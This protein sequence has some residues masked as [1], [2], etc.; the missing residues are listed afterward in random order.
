MSNTSQ[1]RRFFLGSTLAA[2][3]LAATRSDRVIAAAN[4]NSDVN[5]G[6]IA[7][8]GRYGKLNNFFSQVDGVQITGLC[9][10]DEDRVG[11]A[12]AS[13][14]KAK[15]WSDLRDLIADPNIDAV[16]ISTCNHWHCLASIW[17]M[18]AGKHVYVEKPLSHSQWEGQQCVA[19]AEK[20]KRVVQVGTHQRSDPMQADI[21]KFL[22]ED[23]TLGEIKYVRANRFGV[24]GSI[25]KRDTPLEIEKSVAYDLWLGPA[26]DLPIMRNNLQYDWHWDWNTGSGE[27]G[28]WGVHILDDIRNV[29]YQDRIPLPKRVMAGGG[30]VVWDDAGN[31]PNVHF[32]YF[33]TGEAPVILGLTNV[34]G[35]VDGAKPPK[36]PGPSSGYIVYCEGG[37]LEGQRGKFTA[38]DNDGKEMQTQKGDKST[39][40]LI[41]Q[42][43]FIQ[44]V[45]DEDPTQL[46]SPVNVGHDSSGWCNVANIAFRA[47]AAF[48][49]ETAN[50]IHHEE[51][52]SVV[53]DL[54]EHLKVHG[55]NMNHES[56]KL[57][58]VLE[59]DPAEGVFIGEHKDLANPLLK[60]KYRS[61]YEVPEFELVES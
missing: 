38:Y 26:Q 16:V 11:K 48:S 53:G 61:G 20:Y 47:G 50:Q 15:S 41:H 7:C 51:W 24:R 6:F 23:K 44:A 12:Q 54:D 39:G 40:D 31:T 46:N 57:S 30:R 25:G 36:H 55:L 4:G 28:N 29:V 1:T 19:A 21:K 49:Q 37:R 34:P 33:D 22:H 5:L 13:Y 10:P 52:K 35:E 56:I 17:A 3:A 58:P 59:M 45:R 14:P 27:M 18:E 42:T 60:R 9:D 2:G 43:N 32:G 8:G